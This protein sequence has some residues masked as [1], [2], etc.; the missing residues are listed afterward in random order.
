[1]RGKGIPPWQHAFY[2]VFINAETPGTRTKENPILS[3]SAVEI[4]QPEH[5]LRY[6]RNLKDPSNYEKRYP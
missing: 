1:M 5:T 3:L 2:F 4:K 6:Q